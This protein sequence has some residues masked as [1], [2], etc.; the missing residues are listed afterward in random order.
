MT[1][2]T[3]NP[4]RASLPPGRLSLRPREAARALG[5]GE[6]L[7][8]SWTNAG[9]IPHVRLGRAILYPVPALERWLEEQTE[10]NAITAKCAV[11]PSG[12]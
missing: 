6:R 9:R 10:T 11:A 5:V 4:D 2:Q 7:L 3:E 1:V 8:W 12:P